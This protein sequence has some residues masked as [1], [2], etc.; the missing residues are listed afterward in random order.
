MKIVYSN[1]LLDEIKDIRRKLLLDEPGTLFEYTK[2][3][4]R[5]LPLLALYLF[6]TYLILFKLFCS[7]PL[8]FFTIMGKIM[9]SK[10]YGDSDNCSKIIILCWT[11][12]G[13]LAAIGVLIYISVKLIGKI[14][15][16][17][18]YKFFSIKIPCIEQNKRN[19]FF[20]NQT[21]DIESILKQQDTLRTFVKGNDATYILHGDVLEITIKRD[22]YY[23][24]QLFSL[25]EKQVTGVQ[26]KGVL[27]FSY[28]DDDWQKAL[29][30]S[31]I[32]M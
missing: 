3:V 12:L 25:S 8:Q 27:D 21:E 14:Y 22:G 7:P 23:E 6:S 15:K 16:G 30:E 2:L 1:L 28:L 4:L 18:V 13:Y 5:S 19:R 26:E 31:E 24:K 9:Q 32:R 20:Y 11:V 10:L 17:I 29:L